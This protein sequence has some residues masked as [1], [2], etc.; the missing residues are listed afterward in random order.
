MSYDWTLLQT[1]IFIITPFF[2]M[3]ALTSEDEDDGGP[4][5]GGMLQPLHMPSANPI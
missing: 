4:P 3:L 2:V 5:D 1:L